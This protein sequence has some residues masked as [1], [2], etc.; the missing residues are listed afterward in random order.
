[1]PRQITEIKDFLLTARRKD[2]RSVKIKK[3]RT[4]V[5][6]FKVR[7]SKYLYTLCVQDAEKAD[8]LK[9]SLP[10]GLQA[11]L[12]GATK[13]HALLK[14]K[15]DALTMRYRQLLKQI[16]EAKTGMG[17][18][19]K[20]SFFSL[21]EA[22]YAGGDSIKHTVFDN[23]D[24]ASLKVYAS[25]ENVAGVKIPK[26]E[27]VSEPG[28]TK[29]E[30][31]GLG[32]GGQQIQSCRK[33]YVGAIQLLVQLANLQTAFITLD[34][35]LKVTNRRVNALENVVKPKIENTISYILGEL[36]ELEREEFFRLKKVQK[37]KQKV[38]A[39]EAASKAAKD[40]AA[41]VDTGLI[42]T[43]ADGVSPADLLSAGADEDLVRGPMRQP[44]SSAWAGRRR[45]LATWLALLVCC[46]RLEP[47]AASPL[48]EQL[49]KAYLSNEQ[50]EAWIKDYTSRCASISR[51]FSIGRSVKGAELWVLEIAERPG[52][53]EAKPNFKYV[54]NMHGNEPSGRA[55]L[56]Q[57]AEWLCAER[58][59]DGR[60]RAV[61]GGLHLYLMPSM[62]PDGFAARKR[63]NAA[64]VDLNRNFPDPV[65]TKDPRALLRPLPDA[66]PETA[67]MMR[68]SLETH[69]VASANLHEGALVAN[70]PLDGAPDGSNTPQARRN[71]APDDVTFATLASL[72]AR[73]HKTMAASKEFKGGIINGAQ[74]YPVYGGMQDWNYF[75]ARCFGLT[76]EL[77]DAKW[78][79][80]A[81]LPKLWDENRDALL[82]LPLAAALGGVRGVVS[83]RNG[84][85]IEAI[86]VVD[87]IAWS[88]T[89][90]PATGYFNRCACLGHAARR[91]AQP[92]R[93]P[94]RGP[95]PD[96]RRPT[97][98]AARRR[99]LA[100]GSYTLRVF[101][102]GFEPGS[103]KIE[104]PKDYSGV[105]ANFTLQPPTPAAGVEEEDEEESAAAE[106][107]AGA[108]AAPGSSGGGGGSEEL[109]V[110]AS[111]RRLESGR[112]P[113]PG[114]GVA[115]A[116]LL[117][118]LAGAAAVLWVCQGTRALVPPALPVLS[119]GGGSRPG[120]SASGSRSNL[121]P[122]SGSRSNLLSSSGSRSNLAA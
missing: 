89:S 25:T 66:Q 71:P 11:R 21:A 4:G 107:K 55:L 8:K 116:G 52:V 53:R 2:A 75:A 87:G 58:G 97:G 115:A 40:E 33:A 9:Q 120:M 77:S 47:A 99:P 17:D 101:S 69:F 1:M 83:A 22:K 70:Y 67:A 49:L 18:A 73:K 108:G 24:R 27:S 109:L 29:M 111:S 65:A 26:F 38:A 15:A 79:P 68:W 81:D 84:S 63:E 86:V 114:V 110:V 39:R 14:K 10:P 119:S 121:L 28:E 3:T 98:R 112:A 72:Y 94:R 30:L 20:G 92:R 76:L 6:K 51:A 85:A 16:V 80:P 82:A 23:V 42:V 61:L 57:L 13:G 19:M 36:D 122:S 103:A 56:P 118:C 41:L 31:T 44:S 32:K 74:W 46:G 50:L 113:R 93:A 5:T 60:A 95:A 64:G 34:A 117:L 102:E 59:R 90:D 105:T 104:V 37:N 45:L 78:R 7:C 88:T 43:G 54:A 35:A 91:Q 62:N 48:S 96:P 100:P 12:V 106:G